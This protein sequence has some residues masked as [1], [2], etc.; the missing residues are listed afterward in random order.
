MQKAN[1]QEILSWYKNP[2]QRDA[3]LSLLI[4]T[5]QKSLYWHIRKIVIDHDD[6]DDV[7]QNTFIKVWKGLENFKEDSALFTWLYR[8]AT[9][10][11]L[12]F[13][14]QK[15]KRNTQSIHPIEYQLSKSLEGDQYF[16]GDA[17]QLKLQNILGTMFIS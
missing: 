1:D 8:I 5:Y 6:T 4:K 14:R 3:S 9:N 16:K 17:I 11:A 10:E 13:L 7:L 15:E 2:L 12:T